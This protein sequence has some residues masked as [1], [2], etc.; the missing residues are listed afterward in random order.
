MLPIILAF[1]LTVIHFFSNKISKRIEKHHIQIMSFSAGMLVTLIFVD[2][3]PRVVTGVDT[4]PVYVFLLFG[5]VLVHLSEKYIYQHIK[6]RRILMKDL[7]ELHTLGFFLDHLMIGIV[8]AFSFTLSTQLNFIIF[9]PFLLHTISSSMSLEH[10]TEK[11][12]LKVNKVIL[13]SSTLLGALFAVF[14]K[15]TQ[16]WYYS[17]FAFLLGAL[18]YISIRDM[19]PQ[20]K[21]G[22]SMLFIFGFILTLILVLLARTY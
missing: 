5:F 14:L 8:L 2:L 7:A 19:L 13:N 10:I 15:P 4:T 18:L 20:G 6:N 1:I 3:I 9:I 11:M 17:I 21:K 16:F 22:D 12:K